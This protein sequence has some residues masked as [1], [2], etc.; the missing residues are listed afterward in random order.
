MLAKP[1]TLIVVSF[2]SRHLNIILLKLICGTERQNIVIAF[3]F[4][5]LDFV[6]MLND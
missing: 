6:K 5:K 3:S 1:M 4:H 2:N